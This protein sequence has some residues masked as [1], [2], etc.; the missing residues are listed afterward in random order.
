MQEVGVAANSTVLTF[1]SCSATRCWRDPRFAPWRQADQET[2]LEALDAA[3][4]SQLEADS[5]RGNTRRVSIEERLAAARRKSAEVTRP[6]LQ[7]PEMLPK[8]RPLPQYGHP[9]DAY[10][11][12][13]STPNKLSK[14]N[15]DDNSDPEDYQPESSKGSPDSTRKMRR[16]QLAQ[17]RIREQTHLSADESSPAG[18]RSGKRSDPSPSFA[19]AMLHMGRGKSKVVAKDSEDAPTSLFSGDSP[20][21]PP[22]S[23]TRRRRR[24]APQGEG[25]MWSL[26]W[27]ENRYGSTSGAARYCARLPASYLAGQEYR[28]PREEVSQDMW[29][30]QSRTDEGLSDRM[31]CFFHFEPASVVVDPCT[32]D[33]IGS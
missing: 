9:P 17:Q 23:P 13:M 20:P 31:H 33:R 32:S 12:Q 19:R 28:I 6:N 30:A 22:S 16:A 5:G 14:P 11:D 15:E 4:K 21:G 25:L 1:E 2:T 3:Q 8:P 18:A 10:V 24:L 29:G 26:R 7:F 27:N